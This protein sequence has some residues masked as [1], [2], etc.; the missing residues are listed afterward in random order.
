[1]K[2]LESTPGEGHVVTVADVTGLAEEDVTQPL[3]RL[4]I[5][6]LLPDNAS[7]LGGHVEE[8]LQDPE[9]NR[10]RALGDEIL[11]V[12]LAD[13]PWEDD[14]TAR[15]MLVTGDFT[16]PGGDN[17]DVDAELESVI[18]SFARWVPDAAPAQANEAAN[19]AANVQATRNDPNELYNMLF[20]AAEAD[21]RRLQQQWHD[22][23]FTVCPN[24][25]CGQIEGHLTGCDARVCGQNTHAVDGAVFVRGHGCGT[26]YNLRQNRLPAPVP[27]REL[28]PFFAPKRQDLMAAIPAGVNAPL[29]PPPPARGG[30]WVIDGVRVTRWVV[31]KLLAGRARIPAVVRQDDGTEVTDPF[32][33]PL[34]LQ[35]SAPLTQPGTAP[36][37]AAAVP[38]RLASVGR[39][40][41]STQSTSVSFAGDTKAVVDPLLRLKLATAR[42]ETALRQSCTIHLPDTSQP[43]KVLGELTVRRL[44]SLSRHNVD[45]TALSFLLDDLC[46][47]IDGI[48]LD[49]EPNRSAGI[50][51]P[52]PSSSSGSAGTWLSG[53]AKKLSDRIGGSLSNK[54]NGPSSAAAAPSSA[55]SAS[56]APVGS[57]TQ[58]R[59]AVAAARH[60]PPHR[61][62]RIAAMWFDALDKPTPAA[63]AAAAKQG[64]GAATNALV[65]KVE[66]LPTICQ[67]AQSIFRDKAFSLYQNLNKTLPA[68]VVEQLEVR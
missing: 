67:V 63:I 54:T 45:H 40:A 46:T 26:R 19:V 47:L 17:G 34:E 48:L 42:L 20:A 55:A 27:G 59:L 36:S 2:E 44:E 14:E 53:L 50:S 10:R 29:R 58:E 68:E 39:M 13:A 41:S 57:P 43:E 7:S 31:A 52:A 33:A 66:H 9:F 21:A 6:R 65:A 56:S 11:T 8:L 12:R 30:K 18:R 25:I 32:F 23:N 5:K 35:A 3:P 1:M 24:P 49:I 22:E 37:G 15:S 16:A 4:L 61:W 28:H 51:Q 62:Q 38:N 60:E 64:G